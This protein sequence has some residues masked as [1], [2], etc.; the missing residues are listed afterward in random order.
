MPQSSVAKSSSNRI[1]AA[2][3]VLGVVYGDLG[4][5]MLYSLHTAFDGADAVP[6]TVIDVLGVLSLIFWTLVLLISV[7]YVT[8]VLRADNRGEGGI[9]ALIG[10]L[11]P[12]Q[13]MDRARRRA[14]ILF[15]LFGAALLYGGI[16]I[17]PAISILS[18]I[19]GLQ[20]ATPMFEPYIIPITIVV[21]V[22]LF[23]FQSRGT[24]R[25]GVVFG[26]IM[27]LWFVVIGA[28][29]LNAI[30][31]TPLVLKAVNPYYAVAFFRHE[32]LAAFLVLYA[33]FLVTTGGEALYADMGHFG[34]RSIHR[35]WFCFVLPAVLLNYF[36]Q[37]AQLLAHPGVTLPFY[38]LIP[39]W[40]LYPLVI[41]TTAATVI[42]S[43]ATITGAFSLTRQAIQLGQMPRFKIVHTSTEKRGKIYMPAV[44]WILMLGA[45]ALVLGFGSSSHLAAAYGIAVNGAMVVTTV[46]AFHVARERGGWRW[47]AALAFLI[48]FL[49]IDLTYFG[50]NMLK[51]TH[52]GWVPVVVGIAFFTL[53]T[54]W[55]RGG[56]LLQAQVNRHDE[57]LD[58]F[59]GG[60]ARTKVQRV[61]GTAVF[62]TG[63]LHGTP[64]ALRHHIKRNKA[65]HEQVVLLTV[66][67]SNESRVSSDRRIEVKFY[68][69]GFYRVILHYGYMQKPNV[70]SELAVCEARGI[71]ININDTTYY[72][73]RPAPLAGRK[74]SGMSTW[75][76][77]LFAFML[78]NSVKATAYYQIPA[79]Q[80][81]EMGLQVSI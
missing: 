32:G 65:L 1:F 70:P 68:P 15:G 29:G 50:S 25:I 24:A 33:I 38:H 64:A 41:L 22:L 31:H 77:H 73:G 53:M 43:Q 39:A 44:N 3:A 61:P 40:G 18:A 7:K 16:M 80:S 49:I 27:A 34:R 57:R 26:P 30:I 36:G 67:T 19:E 63:R 9:F 6:V 23:A 12:W 48:G 72:I 5:S 17:T 8:F 76:D 62:L 71:D 54:T 55:R 21:L 42:A 4:T 47:P 37:G 69:Q 66:R 51:I 78:R 74:Q 46:L 58:T 81:V 20:V 75:R 2:V 59:I 45:I 13:G 56:M 14:L 35:M 52:G 11:K 10:L 28:L 79:D 60:F